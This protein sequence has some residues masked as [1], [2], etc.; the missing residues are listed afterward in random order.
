M[1][2]SI[3]TSTFFLFFLRNT[4]LAFSCA[5]SKT[6]RTKVK[7]APKVTLSVIHDA[8]RLLCAVLRCIVMRCLSKRLGTGRMCMSLLPATQN[9]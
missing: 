4:L 7:W 6:T 2:N 5:F 3:N 9:E 1:R 8:L